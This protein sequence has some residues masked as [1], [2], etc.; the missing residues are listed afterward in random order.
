MVRFYVCGQPKDE[1]TAVWSKTLTMSCVC[2]VFVRVCLD[3]PYGHLLG[4]G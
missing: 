2:N 3:V 1:P 4:K